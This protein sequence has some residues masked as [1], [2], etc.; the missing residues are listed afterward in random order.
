MDEILKKLQD[1]A[2]YIRATDIKI[3]ALAKE[4]RE[5]ESWIEAAFDAHPNLDLDIRIAEGDDYD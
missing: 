3:K 4:N 2:E 1:A 5:L